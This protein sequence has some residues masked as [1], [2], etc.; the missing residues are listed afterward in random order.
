MNT[1]G[2]PWAAAKIIRDQDTGTDLI[3]QHAYHL[4]LESSTIPLTPGHQT[5]D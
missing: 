5:R 4:N 2:K 3:G 1:S